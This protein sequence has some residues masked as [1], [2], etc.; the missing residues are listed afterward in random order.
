MTHHREHLHTGR[1]G[2]R[3]VGADHALGRLSWGLEERRLR[4]RLGAHSRR[5]GKAIARYR[6]WTLVALTAVVSHCMAAHWEVG[7]KQRPRG[8]PQLAARRRR[9]RSGR[10]GHSFRQNAR[11]GVIWRRSYVVKELG[12]LRRQAPCDTTLADERVRGTAWQ[13]RVNPDGGRR[14]HAPSALH[15]CFT[16]SSFSFTACAVRRA[17]PAAAAP[18]PPPPPAQHN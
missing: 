16:F 15:C 7:E 6:V 4:Q 3:M 17:P 12:G 1:A 5:C 14:V 10:N 2:D 9:S 8:P 13:C 18:G 11:P